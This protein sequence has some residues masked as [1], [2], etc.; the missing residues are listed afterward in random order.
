MTLQDNQYF[1]NIQYGLDTHDVSRYLTITG[2]HSSFNGDHGIICSE[3]C[4]HL[5]I[6]DNVVDHNGLTPWQDPTPTTMSTARC[7]A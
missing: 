6:T 1:G 2:N 5:T 4:D 3:A 7:M